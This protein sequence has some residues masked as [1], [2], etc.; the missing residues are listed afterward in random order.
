MTDVVIVS[1]ARTAVRQIPGGSLGEDRRARTRRNRDRA[2]LERANLKPEQ[3]S[4][5]IPGPGARRRLRTE[6]RAPV[7]HQ[8]GLPAGRARHDDQQGLRLGP[9][10]GDAG[11]QRDHRGRRGHRDRRRPGK[12]ERGAARADRARATAFAWATRSSIDTMIVDGLWDVYNQYH[13]GTTAGERREGIRHLARAVR[14][15]SR[16]CRRTRLRSRAEVGP[17]QRRDR[18]GRDSA[19]QGDPV[20]FATDEFVRH[21]VT[22]EALAGLKPAFS[23]E[24]TVTAANA[25]GLN[26]GA[27][28]VI[29]MSGEEG[30]SARPHAA[31]RASRPY[32]NAGVDPKVMGM[33]PVPASK[34]CLEHAGWSRGRSRP[35]GDQRSVR[36]AGARGAQADGLGHVEDQR[37]R[38]RDRDRPP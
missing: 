21:G 18:A 14:T 30:R 32:A 20:A 36:G 29:V 28:A 7:A 31:L 23:K 34:R 6:S 4:E 27:A 13:M 17:L 26:D 10:G 24:G 38:R 1:A 16:R 12:H 33:G 15:S 35:D 9:E 19:A 5:V 25:S 3:V 2:V 22:A 8:V 11:G 37:Q